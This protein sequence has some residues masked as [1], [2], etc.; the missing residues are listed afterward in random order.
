M[1][2]EQQWTRETFLENMKNASDLLTQ[3][4]TGKTVIPVIGNHDYFPKDQLPG[5]NSD[6]YNEIAEMWK[7]WLP[8]DTIDSFKNGN[9]V[10]KILDLHCMSTFMDRDRNKVFPFPY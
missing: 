5:E 10:S 4:L 3:K 8:G 9:P 1:N 7:E 6:I 2:K